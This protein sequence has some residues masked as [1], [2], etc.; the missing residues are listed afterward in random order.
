MYNIVEQCYIWQDDVLYETF[1][2]FVGDIGQA[3]RPV[4][5]TILFEVILVD[6]R[7]YLGVSVTWDYKREGSRAQQG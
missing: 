6:L 5:G 3:H 1:W 7:H 2:D 4:V